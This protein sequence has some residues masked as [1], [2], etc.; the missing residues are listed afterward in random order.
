M[1]GVRDLGATEVGARIRA[2][3]RRWPPPAVMARGA[4]LVLLGLVVAVFVWVL[5]T[6]SIHHR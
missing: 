1:L 4:V 3:R 6:E 5:W 2:W